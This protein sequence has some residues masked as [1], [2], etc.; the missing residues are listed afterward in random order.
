MIG[1]YDSGFLT[2]AHDDESIVR[3]ALLIATQGNRRSETHRALSEAEFRKLVW[4][5]SVSV[6]GLRLGY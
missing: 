4:S 6:D 3:I 5:Y 1:Q 2:E